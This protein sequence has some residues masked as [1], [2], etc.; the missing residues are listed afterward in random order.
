[1]EEA[2]VEHAVA[3]RLEHADALEDV[4]GVG[5]VAGLEVDE[6]HRHVGGL[7]GVEDLHLVGDV[8]EV[9]DLGDRRVEALQRAARILGVEGPRQDVLAG[10]I[11]EQGAGDRGLADAALVGSDE[12]E[13]GLHWSSSLDLGSRDAVYHGLATEYIALRE[14]PER[15]W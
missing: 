13:C 6:R 10:E 12:N 2:E 4:E 9:D 8:A 15:Q 11:V 5:H 7:E 3:G 14:A 1:M